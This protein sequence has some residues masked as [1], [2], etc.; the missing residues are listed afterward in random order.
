MF[1]KYGWRWRS[2][3]DSSTPVELPRDLLGHNEDEIDRYIELR[4]TEIEIYKV[5]L[6]NQTLVKMTSLAGHALFLGYNSTMCFATKDF[7]ALKPNCVYITDDSLEYVNMCKHNWREIGVWD[8]E[9]KSLQTFDS[10]LLTN[11]WMNWPSPVW[12]TP[13]LF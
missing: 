8:I 5:D 13:S 4:T 12:I 6:E 2:Y 1:C 9:N 3:T 10:D 11:S 7:P